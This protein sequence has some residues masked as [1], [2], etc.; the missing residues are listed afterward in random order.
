[1]TAS[2]GGLA[3]GLDTASIIS[4][5]M[6][7]EASQQTQLKSRVATRTSAKTTMQAINAKLAALT[8]A[9]QDLAKSRNWSPLAAS[10]SYDKV[11]VTTG[12]GAVP[13]QLDLTVGSL[14][15][16]HRLTFATTAAFTDVVVSGGTT[17]TLDKLD[18]TGPVT[19]DTGD[20]T[21]GGLVN[22]IN[23]AGAGVRASTVRLDDGTQR[24]MVESVAT[25]AAGDFTLT[26][27]DGSA[28][29]GGAAVRAGQDASITVGA[30]T[31]HSSTN[32]FTDLMPGISVTLGSGAVA[33]TAVTIGA[34]TDATAM[35]AKV[36][37][38]V[39]SLNAVLTDI[40]AATKAGIGG[41]KAGVLAGD[42]TMRGVRD[43]LLAALYSTTGGTLADAGVQL[44]RYGKVTFDE[45]AFKTAYAA[46]PAAV[47]AKF[48]DGAT[49]GYMARLGAAASAASN[50]GTG[51]I[52]QALQGVDNVIK[53]LNNRIEAWDTRLELRRTALTRQFSALETALS[54]MHSQ[55]SWL[56]GQIS[57]LPTSG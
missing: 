13:T 42:S 53:D 55:S 25:G 2:I 14:A 41:A 40:D 16:S 57:S 43:S 4:Q 23:A 26:S 7:L 45:E 21:L 48:V 31:I 47:A 44:D 36:K 51:S 54:R 52:T 29:L 35:S 34:T 24:L 19:I 10:S 3:S 6:Q 18:G 46:D 28:L 39:D 22:A 12:T 49:P 50:A 30:D 33:G 27:G 5:L 9:A 17:V 37:T 38:L 56:A 11:T 1:M 32:T 20:G 15:Q 8:T